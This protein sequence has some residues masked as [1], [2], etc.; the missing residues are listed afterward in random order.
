PLVPP[1]NP[2][3]DAPPDM[4]WAVTRDLSPAYNARLRKAGVTALMFISIAKND[5]LWGLLMFYN[6][7]GP[8]YVSHDARMSCEL[9]AHYLSLQLAAKEAAEN[10]KYVARVIRLNAELERSNTELD[11]FAW[12]ASHD[13][14]EPLRGIHRYSDFLMEDY[15]DKLDE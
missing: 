12:V 2:V 14:K 13:L 11:S 15:A 9:M 5:R 1:V 7:T 3:D 8:K 6:H 4:S 10:H